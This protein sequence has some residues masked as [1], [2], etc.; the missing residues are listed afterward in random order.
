MKPVKI[1][2]MHSAK[3]QEFDDVYLAGWT[4]SV[5]PHPSSVSN[6]RLYEERRI[7]YVALTRARQRVLV[8]YSFVH[9]VAHF[10]PKGKRKDVTEQVKPLFDLLSKTPIVDDSVGSRALKKPKIQQAAIEWDNSIG[11]KEIIA[12]KGLPPHFFLQISNQKFVCLFQFLP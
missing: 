4:E 9:S 11:F 6:D 1:I 7:A 2:T 10:G 12:G 8:T 3:G 5:F